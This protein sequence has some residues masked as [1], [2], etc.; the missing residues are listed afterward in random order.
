VCSSD[1]NDNTANQPKPKVGCPK[2]F[3]SFL[4]R[5][6]ANET[7]DEEIRNA[8]YGVEGREN[9]EL[10][11]PNGLSEIHRERILAVLSK[12]TNKGKHDNNE[13]DE[14]T[15]ETIPMEDEI[16]EIEAKL[17]D[18]TNEF[19]RENSQKQ[20]TESPNLH[21]PVNIHRSIKTMN[22]L[23]Q[24]IS[25]LR[26]NPSF[27]NHPAFE[28]LRMNSH[29]S[30]ENKSTSDKILNTTIFVKQGWTTKKVRSHKDVSKK[31][32]EITKEDNCLRVSGMDEVNTLTNPRILKSKVLAAF[33][34]AKD[35]RLQM[36]GSLKVWF[37]TEK[38]MKEGQDQRI[39]DIFGSRTKAR[40]STNTMNTMVIH[41]LPAGIDPDEIT[42]ILEDQN[43]QVHRLKIVDSKKRQGRAT[44]FL[45]TE[46]HGGKMYILEKAS[47]TIGWDKFSV[48]DYIQQDIIQCFRC[49]L[50]GHMSPTCS[51]SEKC[52]F[53]SE[54]HNGSECPVRGEVKSYKCANCSRNHRANHPKCPTR[55]KQIQ[56]VQ[57]SR[58]SGRGEQ[59]KKLKTVLPDE[60]SLSS[61]DANTGPIGSKRILTRSRKMTE[62][63]GS[64]PIEDKLDELMKLFSPRIDA[65]IEKSLDDLIAKKILNRDNV[66]LTQS[67]E[68]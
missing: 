46:T 11:L 38:D 32:T 14:K 63:I 6:I 9:M 28:L 58:K 15:D 59:F 39:E 5:V 62:T 49:Q 18:E 51:K 35:A 64:S 53:C 20:S 27:C 41:N 22:D 61:T 30:N 17:E 34:K 54:N 65:A 25:D 12:N 24:M 31:I 66:I 50:F 47:I 42:T 48:T 60:R 1:L 10:Y 2:G 45:T 37:P 26:E 44:G 40:A 67:N 56:N 7:T 8:F 43:V 33:P 52:L 55:T 13:M 57:E 16:I 68:N 36:N 19:L 4:D 21:A 29:L 23:F 3:F